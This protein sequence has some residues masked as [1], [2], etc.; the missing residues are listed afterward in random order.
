MTNL[1]TVVT[2]VHEP[3]VRYLPEAYESLVSQEMP[4]GWAWQWIV[5][6]DGQTGAASAVLPEDPRISLGTGRNGGTGTA[7]NMALTRAEGSLVRVLDADD[8]LTPGALA[9]EIAVFTQLPGLGWTTA[10]AL[11]LLPDGSTVGWEHTEP[12]EGPLTRTHVLDYFRR[13]N[14]RLPVHPATLCIRTEL[15]LALGGWMALPAGEDTGLLLA[16]SVVAD[17]YFIGAPGLLYRKHPDQ[18]TAQAWWTGPS[19]WNARMRLIEARALAL[20]DLW[21]RR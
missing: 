13:N 12:P 17:G 11:D 3:S 14:Y 5:Q 18:V 6:E 9:R 8:R 7:R 19:E 16:A 1:I 21:G 4:P 20:R 2:P 10:S 15:A